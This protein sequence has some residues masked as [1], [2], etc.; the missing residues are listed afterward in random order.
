[1]EVKRPTI[2]SI[3]QITS[4]VV[5]LLRCVW[6]FVTP[7]TAPRQVPL[8]FTLSQ[9]LLKLISTEAVMLSNQL[10]L[11]CPLLLL[12]STFPNIRAFSSESDLHINGQSTGASASVSTL[13]MSIQGW[14]PLGSIGLISLQSK[15]LIV[16]NFFLLWATTNLFECIFL[17]TC[18]ISS[19]SKFLKTNCYVKVHMHFKYWDILFDIIPKRLYTPNNTV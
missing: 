11:C 3:I 13:P 18:S 6:L 7:W 8:S 1:M 15:G 19:C 5:Q 4:M 14:F 9:S 2:Q 17:F 16:S 12:P 10:I